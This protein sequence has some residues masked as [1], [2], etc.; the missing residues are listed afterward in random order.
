VRPPPDRLLQLRR[1]SALLWTVVRFGVPLLVR[2]ALRRPGYRTDLPVKVRMALE[3]LGLTYLKLG[4]YLAMRFDILP[5]DICR[6]LGKLFDDVAPMPPELARRRIEEELGAPMAELFQSFGEEPL[7]AASVAQVHDARTRDG[8]RVA[9]K[10][11]RP[12]IERIFR[13][14]IALLR[15]MTRAA[16]AFHLLGRLS[17]TEMLDQFAR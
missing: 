4:Q 2:A 16:D 9:V 17:A 5:P 1:G 11:Q 10:V 14:D 3:D 13:A 12:G 6:E 7:A 8:A 15:R